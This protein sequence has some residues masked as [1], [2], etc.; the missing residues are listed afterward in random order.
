MGQMVTTVQS[1]GRKEM[2]D[3][4]FST[5]AEEQDPDILIDRY[6]YHIRTNVYKHGG[7]TDH[8]Y[9]TSSTAQ[10]G[11]GSFSIGNL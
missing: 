11:G 4:S 7:K 10:G 1:L 6:Q 2:E 8:L 9:V 3:G 5:L